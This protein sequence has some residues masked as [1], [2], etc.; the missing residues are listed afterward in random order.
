MMDKKEFRKL[1]K[2]NRYNISTL[3]EE[4]GICRVTLSNAVNHGKDIPVSFAKA[5]AQK[6][7]TTVETIF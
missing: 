7:N 5:I 2:Q 1:M 3:A 6:L 4:V